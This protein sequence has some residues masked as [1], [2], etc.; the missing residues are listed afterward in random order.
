MV[1]RITN[2]PL[3]VGIWLYYRLKCLSSRR[4]S[5]QDGSQINVWKPFTRSSK[6]RLFERQVSA[7]GRKVKGL[8]E[9]QAKPARAIQIHGSGGKDALGMSSVNPSPSGQKGVQGNS[10]LAQLFGSYSGGKVGSPD[11]LRDQAR[12][13][14]ESYT[15]LE[16]RLEKIEDMLTQLLLGGVKVQDE[17]TEP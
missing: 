5:I 7:A 15:S 17:Q 3:L 8:D 1:V 10:L 14:D 16:N 6:E 11:A 12:G 4:L 13:G 9:D 2:F